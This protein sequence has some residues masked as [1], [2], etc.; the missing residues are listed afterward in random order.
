LGYIGATLS[1][2][3][4]GPL[5]DRVLEPAVGGP[6]WETVAPLVGD[7]PGSGMG[8]LLVITGALIISVTG[9][10][11]LMPEVRHLETRQPDYDG[12]P[13]RLE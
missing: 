5:V 13:A 9:V 12:A 4:V 3:L 6:G 2:L 1:F 8:L 11:A 7:A 10:A